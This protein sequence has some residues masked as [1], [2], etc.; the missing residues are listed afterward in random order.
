M[1]DWRPRWL[2]MIRAPNRIQRDQARPG[3]V[4]SQA[5][6]ASQEHAW[7]MHRTRISARSQS[8]LSSF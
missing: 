4:H 3:G 6:T 5:A 1:A 7:A 2:R 8:D